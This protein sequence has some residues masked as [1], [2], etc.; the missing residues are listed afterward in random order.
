[1]LQKRNKSSLLFVI[2]QC[3]IKTAFFDYYSN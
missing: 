3:L 2:F 1:M